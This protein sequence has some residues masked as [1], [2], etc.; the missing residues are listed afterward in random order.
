MVRRAE[1]TVTTLATHLAGLLDN[2]K[3]RFFKS[4][5]ALERKMVRA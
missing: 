4:P 2:H 3:G 5:R 1:Q